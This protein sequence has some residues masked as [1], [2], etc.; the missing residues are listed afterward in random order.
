VRLPTGHGFERHL[1]AEGFKEAVREGIERFYGPTALD[2]FATGR[3]HA[4]EEALLFT[5]LRKHKSSYGA[6]VAEAIVER[7]DEQ[8]APALPSGVRQLLE[9]AEE[10][11]GER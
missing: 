3:N 11:L 9:R 8:G 10:V 1:L 6:S 5:F 4:D 2:D 7:Q